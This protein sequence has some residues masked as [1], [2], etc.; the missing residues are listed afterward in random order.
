MNGSISPT[1]L[2]EDTIWRNLA[3]FVTVLENDL[4]GNRL[5]KLTSMTLGRKPKLTDFI[6]ELPMR[7]G[8]S[9][10]RGT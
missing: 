10:L 2:I 5:S 4:S 8:R 9:S 7:W 3:V 1:A 6:S